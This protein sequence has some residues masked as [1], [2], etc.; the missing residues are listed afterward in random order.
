MLDREGEPAVPLQGNPHA[1]L[2]TAASRHAHGPDRQTAHPWHQRL[3]GEEPRRHRVRAD[4]HIRITGS[5]VVPGP[6]DGRRGDLAQPAHELAGP[7]LP[8]LFPIRQGPPDGQR[9]LPMCIVRQWVI[10]GESEVLM[11][12]VG[13]RWPRHPTPLATGVF[14]GGP[15]AVSKSTPL[16]GSRPSRRGSVRSQWRSCRGSSRVPGTSGRGRGDRDDRLRIGAAVL[17]D[18][19]HVQRRPVLAVAVMCEPGTVARREGHVVQRA[20]LGG[21]AGVGRPTRRSR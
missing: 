20:R 15:A 17:E 6:H 7:L 12:R 4:G 21:R 18:E 10:S 14:E 5:Q 2:G 9:H 19:G 13:R 16:P 1:V 11:T 8:D 3:P